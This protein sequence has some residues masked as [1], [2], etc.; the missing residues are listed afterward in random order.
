MR[1]T[2]FHHLKAR[3]FKSDNFVVIYVIVFSN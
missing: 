1:A 3:G 2:Y